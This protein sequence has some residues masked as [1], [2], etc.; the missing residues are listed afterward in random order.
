MATNI[1]QYLN[2]LLELKKDLANNLVAK[3][4]TANENEGFSSLV[5]KVSNIGKDDTSFIGD[6]SVKGSFSNIAYVL[7]SGNFTV[8]EFMMTEPMKTGFH[9]DTGL[10]TINGFIYFCNDTTV[11]TTYECGLAGILTFGSDGSEEIAVSILGKTHDFEK[12]AFFRAN[13]SPYVISGGDI[14]VNPD[15]SGN[16]SY[17]PLRYGADVKYFWV[18]W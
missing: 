18:A 7:S 5:P 9:I 10:T 1:S 13:N 16:A 12:A 4:L 3:G 14:N 17:T 2:N 11:V 8:G 15:F 6:T